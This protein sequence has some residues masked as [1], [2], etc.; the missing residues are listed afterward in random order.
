MKKFLSFV[1]IFSVI[2]CCSVAAKSNDVTVTIPEY[3]I[4]IDD[5]SIYY[6]DSLYPFINYKGITYLPMTYEYSRAM[7]LTTSWLTDSAFMVAYQP[8][9]DILPVYETTVNNKY[10]KAIIP[11]GYRIYVNGKEFDNTKAEYPLLNFRGVTYFPMTWDFAV[12]EFGW[13]LNFENNILNIST[14]I[15][16]KNTWDI[17]EKNID[18]AI[19]S[20]SIFLTALI[21]ISI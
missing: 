15:N 7:N 16:K 13:E 19:L 18:Y 3:Q 5:A 1:I 17:E 9:Y 8:S 2:L 20:T 11:K 12:N 21:S 10:D 6:N 14:E 4:I